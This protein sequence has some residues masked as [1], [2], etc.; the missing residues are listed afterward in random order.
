MEKTNEKK[1][2]WGNEKKSISGRRENSWE[3]RTPNFY[4]ENKHF[5][6]YVTNISSYFTTKKYT[7]ISK[8]VNQTS[9]TDP[10]RKPSNIIVIHNNS[11]HNVQ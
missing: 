1:A 3:G 11:T 5:I 8:N 6:C 9:R 4:F 10:D 2:S 7:N